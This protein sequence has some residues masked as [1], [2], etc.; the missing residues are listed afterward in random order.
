MLFSSI[1]FAIFLPI[2]FLLYWFVFRR[3]AQQNAF[4]L[5]ASM[6]FYGWWDW[7][8]LGLVFIS[9]ATDYFAAI[10]MERAGTP[11]RRR[12]LLVISLAINL[13]MLGFFKYYNFF[14]GSF[15]TAFSFLGQGIGLRTLNIVLPVGISFYTFQ[16]LSYT[17]D[18]YRGQLKPSRDPVAF[19]AFILFFPQLVAGPI[20]RASHLLPQFMG[21]RRFD[22][23]LARDGLRQMLWG[24]FK[25]VVI[26]DNCSIY[27]DMVWSDPALQYGSGWWVALLAFTFQIY[28]DFSG[29]S[30]IAIGSSRLFGFD[31][32]RNFNFPFFSRDVGEFWRRWHISLNTWF[33]DYLYLPLGGSKGGKWM[34]ARNVAAIF[35]VSGLWHGANWTFVAWGAANL[36]L[37]LP[38]IL[39]ARHRKFTGP[40]APGRL[41]PSWSDAVHMLST[42]VL[43]ALTRIF[44]RSPT[45]E[46]AFHAFRE[47]FSPSVFRAPPGTLP[48]HWATMIG[49]AGLLLAVEW[50]QREQQHGL[51]LDRVP[52]RPLRWG[53]YLTLVAAMV[54]LAP[55]NGDSFIYFQF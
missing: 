51:V 12:L 26:A 13:G 45:I 49:G 7:R 1:D 20:E 28:A 11:G 2:V 3:H 8:Y 53:I 31:L 39:L 15:H 18:V 34:V 9:A 55:N 37:F 17:I 43:I 52:Q 32:K 48:S 25:K 22:P 19:G 42:F 6:V 23:A 36:L 5:L 54:L 33:R 38:S 24:F 29:Y 21:A 30:D 46:V 4:I 41:L 50:V 47:M 35:I 10:G 40:L 44:F 16:T 27:A 14:V